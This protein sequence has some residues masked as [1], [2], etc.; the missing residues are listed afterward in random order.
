MPKCKKEDKCDCPVC[1]DEI[2]S[3]IP[4]DGI[5]EDFLIRT[6]RIM[7]VGEINEIMSTHVCSYL[8]MFSLTKEPIFLYI[9]SPGGSLID[10][11]SII[12]QMRLSKC[13]IYTIV[14][15]EAC[16]M[17]ALIAAFGSKGCRFITE[18]SSI[19]LHTIILQNI[20]E[21]I[22]R[23]ERTVDYI[24]RDWEAKLCELAK[25]MR[26]NLKRLKKM[27]NKTKWLSPEEAIKIG[28]IDGI[29]TPGI[30]QSIT[31]GIIK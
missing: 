28:L 8:Q 1:R 11:Y 19:M 15:G 20:S 7:I 13:P 29:L 23:H 14:R 3:S 9:N 17:A 4:L 24:K 2:D 30:E 12:D 21:P 22:D 16:S 26:I 10:G 27:I 31:E 6:R 18:N 5:A 25:T